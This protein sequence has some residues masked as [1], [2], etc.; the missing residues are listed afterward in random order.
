LTLF[1]LATDR[2][3]S[4][5][6][7]DIEKLLRRELIVRDTDV[8]LLND[9]FRQFIRSTEKIDFVTQEEDKAKKVSPWHTLKGPI[10]VVLVAVTIFL[11]VTQRDIYTSSLAIVTAVT[12][13]IP[14]FF[15]VLTIFHSD[16]FARPS[17]QS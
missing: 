9:S 11:F 1:H 12:T 6:D 16:P 14:A 17:G 15:K 8:H 2:L 7:P 4:H 3:L 5:R 10:L 13:I